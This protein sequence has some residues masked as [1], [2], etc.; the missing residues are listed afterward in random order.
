MFV[1]AS[2]IIASNIY[3]KDDAPNYPRGNRV[4]LGIAVGN[5]FLYLLTKVYYV[6]RNQ[7]RDK[8]WNSMTRE[9][10]LQYLETTRDE[11]NKRY[12]SHNHHIYLIILTCESDWI[13]VS[14]TEPEVRLGLTCGDMENR[15]TCSARSF[16]CY[17]T[18]QIDR[19]S[20][21]VE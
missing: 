10:Q 17:S 20:R 19:S 18:F 4:L 16:G 9:E 13:S 7:A 6:K 12:C 3:R 8:K 11:G 15:I 2:G 1:Q 14:H 5:I 21:E